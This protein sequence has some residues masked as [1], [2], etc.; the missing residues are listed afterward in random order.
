MG[1]VF[2][3]ILL[4]GGSGQVGAEIVRRAAPQLRVQAPGRTAAD[5]ADPE[6]CA[7]LV[8]SAEADVAIN[9]A[10]FTAVDRAESETDVAQVVNAET[11][12]AIAQ[13][14]AARGLPLLHVSTDYVFDGETDRPWREDDAP[15]PLNVY[16]R[17]KLDGESAVARAGGPHAILRTSW[18]FSAH[19]G[20][21]VKTMVRLGRERPELRVVDD[22]TGGPTAAADV[23]DALLRVAAAFVEG[24]GVSGV[25]HFA[26]A[27]TVSWRGFAEAIFA[28]LDWPQRPTVAPIA[29]A[30]WP[31]PARRPRAS[32]LDCGRIAAAYGVGQPAW[33]PALDT[34]LTDL[35]EKLRG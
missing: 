2:V 28:R 18:V 12:A 20:N 19:G 23:A 26:G 7:A 22:Q 31:T 6:A 33:R 24:R 10:A 21:F 17:T 1:D 32:A 4:F 8:A 14:A 29:T 35:G 11:P 16:G 9:C 27:P 25:F 30:D 3:R 13:A 34:V 5:F 15:A